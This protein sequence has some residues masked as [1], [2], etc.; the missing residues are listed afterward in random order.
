MEVVV[1]GGQSYDRGRIYGK[2]LL[3]FIQVETVETV[4]AVE[5]L[6]EDR[7]AT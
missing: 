7:P 1:C 2:S 3:G 4:E 5:A 6:Y